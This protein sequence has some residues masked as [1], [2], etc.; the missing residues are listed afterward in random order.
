MIMPEAVAPE[1]KMRLIAIEDPCSKLQGIF[2]RKECCLFYDSLAYSAASGGECA[3]FRG[4]EFF[5]LSGVDIE[6]GH[7]LNGC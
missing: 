2:D 4:S 5:H 1:A 3:R 6:H 7:S